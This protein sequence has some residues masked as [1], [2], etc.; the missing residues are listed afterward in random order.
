M[1]ALHPISQNPR[2]FGKGEEMIGHEKLYNDNDN[3]HRRP[4]L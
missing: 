4:W 2:V 3:A 1:I